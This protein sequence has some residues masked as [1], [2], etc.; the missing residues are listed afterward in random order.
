MEM[1]YPKAEDFINSYWPELDD[2]E[3]LPP[4]KEFSIFELENKDKKKENKKKEQSKDKD[5]DPA[6]IE[7][8]FENKFDK[9]LKK[10]MIKV[11]SP[12]AHKEFKKRHPMNSVVF[13]SANEQIYF[14]FLGIPR[15]FTFSTKDNQIL[16][17]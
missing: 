10:M 9:M 17:N 8:E 12:E 11:K 7:K 4:Y 13:D 14:S 1:N 2:A 16:G 5:K 3:E 15:E 6:L